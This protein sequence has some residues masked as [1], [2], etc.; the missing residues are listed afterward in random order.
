MMGKPSALEGKM[1]FK[2]IQRRVRKRA[3][4]KPQTPQLG[5]CRLLGQRTDIDL[6]HTGNHGLY[7][8]PAGKKAVVTAVILRM[9]ASS[10]ARGNA[11]VSVGTGSHG[12][13]SNILPLSNSFLQTMGDSYHMTTTGLSAPAKSG[14]TVYLEVSAADCGRIAKA[15]VELIG[16]LL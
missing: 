10:D 6:T 14:E 12:N 3:S 15:T 9:S 5:V 13:F 7:C 1:K 11:E 2:I 16:Y 4:Q 8:V